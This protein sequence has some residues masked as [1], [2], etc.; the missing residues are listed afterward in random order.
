MRITNQRI[1]GLIALVLVT[2]FTVHFLWYPFYGDHFARLGDQNAVR[3][4]RHWREWN[5]FFLAGIAA[6]WVLL[7][8]VV[9]RRG[10]LGRIIAFVKS[11]TLLLG[12]VLVELL[13]IA[14]Y[15]Y[16]R[17]TLLRP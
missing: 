12:I 1:E 8:R 11:A 17:Y 4:M 5:S 3:A 13:I 16:I 10:D 9:R 6:A 2:G 14:T 15:A 7:Y